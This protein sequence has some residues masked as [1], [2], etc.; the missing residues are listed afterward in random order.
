MVLLRITPQRRGSGIRLDLLR[1]GEMQGQTRNESGD[2]AS[3]ITKEPE[4]L[5][6]AA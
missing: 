2:L 3:G 5:R 6:L 4:R 1:Q